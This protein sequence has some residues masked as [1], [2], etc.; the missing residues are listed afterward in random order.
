M[1]SSP[2]EHGAYTELFA[3]LSPEV[4]KRTT[5]DGQWGTLMQY[6]GDPAI[7]MLNESKSC[8]QRQGEVHSGRVHG[9]GA[10]EAILGVDG[11]A[12]QA[13]PLRHALA[14][15]NYHDLDRK[16]VVSAEKSRN[17]ISDRCARTSFK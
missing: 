4:T 3:G 17:D 2:P 6:S 5:L 11:G 15:D 9:R 13:V 12:G 8:S 10:G 1:L 16:H 7:I 14:R